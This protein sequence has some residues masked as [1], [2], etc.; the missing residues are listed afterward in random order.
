MLSEYLL[1]IFLS[2]LAFSSCLTFDSVKEAV[3]YFISNKILLRIENYIGRFWFMIVC[4]FLGGFLFASFYFVFIR[5]F[6]S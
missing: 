2:I 1:Y 6:G 3:G 4:Y 5:I